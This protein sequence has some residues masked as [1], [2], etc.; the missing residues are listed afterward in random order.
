MIRGS[1]TSYMR[2]YYINWAITEVSLELVFSM[3]ITVGLTL[4]S[5]NN[6]SFLLFRVIPMFPGIIQG[7][8]VNTFYV[9]CLPLLRR[10]TM[11]S[12]Y[13]ELLPYISEYSDNNGNITVITLLE[14]LF[15]QIPGIYGYL[16]NIRVIVHGTLNNSTIQ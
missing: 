2:I 14:R 10:I 9:R 1:L 12:C 15:R 16:E 3:A 8:Q 13:S 7:T 5:G 4:C 6:G 11:F